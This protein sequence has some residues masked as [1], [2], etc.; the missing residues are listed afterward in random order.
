MK[1]KT[2]SLTTAV[3]AGLS[4]GA[5]FGSDVNAATNTSSMSGTITTKYN[6]KGNI[7][8]LNANGVYQN[9]YVGKNQKFRVWEKGTINGRTM[10]RIGTQ[11]QWI[12]A[13]FTNV[14][15]GNSNAARPSSTKATNRVAASGT[16]VV[17]Y[18]GAG[19]VRLLDSNGTFQ[20]QYVAKN[21]KWRVF[22]SALING[23]LM[24]R[25]G[26]ER[27]WIPAQ[28]VGFVSNT[29]TNNSS[30]S[31]R[32]TNPVTPNNG[33][34]SQKPT[35]PNN[36][37]HSN[38]QKPTNPTT[39]SN[40]QW[41]DAQIKEAQTEFINYVNAW[42]TSQGLPAFT[43]DV[44]WLQ[45]GAETRANDNLQMF[46]STGNISHTRPDGSDFET[47]FHSTQGVIGGE[48]IGYVGNSAGYTPKEAAR[49]IA[50]SFIA[51]GP[52]GGHYAVLH[53]APG[54]HPAIGVAF[55]STYRN[56]QWVYLLN[57]E[58]GSNARLA[59]V[60]SVLSLTQESTGQGWADKWKGKTAPSLREYVYTQG[61]RVH[62]RQSDFPTET[63]YDY[64]GS[65]ASDYLPQ[66]Q[67]QAYEDAWVNYL[68]TKYNAI[69]E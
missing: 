59:H 7:R 28:Y 38:N 31:Q 65:D 35:T 34:N 54:S 2:L 63:G 44:A 45:Q 21:T 15:A 36:G 60:H 27:Q 12:P 47:A 20:N 39:P 48:N 18:Q 58:T 9:Q 13:D 3:L 32:P 6:G 4:V 23:R 52:N 55:R 68:K 37:N 17:T 51:E 46:N 67:L 24:Y 10:Y 22:E 43:N 42:R 30:N 41:S 5:I 56:G 50:Q 66:D 29:N 53:N 33:N 69:V 14:N 25:L 64:T 40:G 1:L 16:V 11:N 26:S 62:V 19:S 49:S 8:L 57:M 61:G